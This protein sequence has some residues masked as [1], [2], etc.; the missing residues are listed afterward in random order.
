MPRPVYVDNNMVLSAALALPVKWSNLKEAVCTA[1]MV[2]MDPE[3]PKFYV[4]ALQLCEDVC[5]GIERTALNSRW[6]PAARLYCKGFEETDFYEYAS[7]TEQALFHEI[8]H[9]INYRLDMH[10]RFYLGEIVD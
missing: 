4:E 2:G 1:L 9:Q 5:K 8:R 7:P 10:H 3:T 6:H